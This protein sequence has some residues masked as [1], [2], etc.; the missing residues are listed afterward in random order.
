MRERVGMQRTGAA[1]GDQR[2]VARIVALLDRHE[3]QRAEHVLVD[4]V[5]DALGRVFDETDAER[6][7]DLLH[8]LV[9]RARGRA[10]CRR[11][12]SADSGR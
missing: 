4:D 1:E 9:R 3:P 12:A 7:G 2:E 11:R 6:V 5:D 8:R 10:S